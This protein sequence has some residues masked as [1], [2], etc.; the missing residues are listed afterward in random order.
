M[1]V[2]SHQRKVR[3]ARRDI[4]KLRELGRKPDAGRAEEEQHG[5]SSSRGLLVSVG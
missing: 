4:P 5:A 2:A 3:L 1:Q